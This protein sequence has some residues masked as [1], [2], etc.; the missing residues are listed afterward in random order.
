[1]RAA[2]PE[3]VHIWPGSPPGET[4]TLP[5]EEDVNKATDEPVGGR[6]IIKLTNVSTPTLSVFRPEPD[7]TRVQ[8]S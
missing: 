2:A 4:K 6:P 5:P 1:M 7:K 8:P 3:V